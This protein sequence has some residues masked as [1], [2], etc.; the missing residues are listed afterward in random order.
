MPVELWYTNGLTHLA[1]P[2]HDAVH[3]LND[4]LGTDDAFYVI[5]AGLPA[6]DL[7]VWKAE[8][9][10][11]V[12]TDTAPPPKQ[13]IVQVAA[14]C[15]HA[16]LD[17]PHAAIT[18]VRLEANAPET[19]EGSIPPERLPHMCYTARHPAWRITYRTVRTLL[20]HRWHGRIV[21]LPRPRTPTSPLWSP[22]T[23]APGTT[24]AWV[25][26]R[27]PLLVEHH[28]PLDA[29][30][31]A[32]FC[33]PCCYRHDGQPC[34]VPNLR[35]EVTMALQSPSAALLH[36]ETSE[37]S[38][39]LRLEG[40]WRPLAAALHHAARQSERPL[41]VLAYHLRR[42]DETTLVADDASLVIVEPDWL[43][44]VRALVEADFCPRS[45]LLQRFTPRAPNA[46]AVRGNII[47]A[48]FEE[49]VAHVPTSPNEWK[50][51]IE[52]AWRMSAVHLALLNLNV[53]EFFANEV[54]P[55]LERLYRWHQA[56]P[57]PTP[58][59][60]SETFLLAPQVGLKGRI[61]A[62]WEIPGNVWVGELKTGKPWGERI[63]L[64]DQVQLAAYVLMTLARGWARPEGYQ[65]FVLYPNGDGD[66]AVR[67]DA[68]LNPHVF[69]QVVIARNRVVLI[70]H[71]GYAPFEQYSANKC[72]KCVAA[73]VCEA[74]AVL[75]GHKDT[76]PWKDVRG[77]YGFA[78]HF[79]ATTRRW[80]RTWVRLLDHEL[81][82]VKAAHAALWAMT[83]EA[84]VQT[85]ATVILDRQTDYTDA[86]A[87]GEG[88]FY[89]FAADNQSELRAGDYVLLSEAPGPLRGRMAE[90]T[91]VAIDETSLTVQ[92]DEPLEFT[93]QLVD[94]YTS[95]DLLTRQYTPLWLWLKQPPERRDL[96][97]RHRAPLFDAATPRLHHPPTIGDR[98]LNKRQQE[99]VA[100]L[101][102][103]RDYM[104][105]QGPPGTG[106]TTLIAALVRECLARGERV[107]LA[108]GT[109]T[110][111]DN[112][113][114]ALMN[115]GLGDQVV[116]LGNT[117]RTDTHVHDR[118][119]NRLAYHDDVQM[120]IEQTRRLLLEAPVLAATA[121][122][123]MRGTW[124]GTLR[125]DVAIVDEAGQM[126][127]PATLAPLRFAKRFV[128]I[129]D[130]KQL[131]PVVQSEGR[132]RMSDLM[133]EDEPPR[134]SRSLFEELIV[135]DLRR[136]GNATILLEE[137]YRMNAEICRIAS[138]R[139]YDNRLVPGTEA[140]AQARLVLD[141]LPNDA[142]APIRDPARPV[143]WV[144]TP[145]A[146]SGVPRQND[147]EA[148][149]VADLLEG[150]FAAGL[151]WPQVGVIAPFR[152]Q[153]AA[154]RRVLARR[155][156]ET[157]IA[158]IRNSVDT[159]DRFQGQERDLIIVSL[160]LYAPFVPDL[161]RDERRLNVAITRARRKLI[162]LGTLSVL[163]TEPIY[164]ALA[165]TL[166]IIP[167]R[168]GRR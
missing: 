21:P 93:P 147:I 94:Q 57:R 26:A 97:I 141:A 36:L 23:Y 89:T 66:K 108:A 54:R 129:G 80:F 117:L 114:R 13:R 77:R 148:E 6:A 64:G 161:L 50:R 69:Q 155:F 42:E 106:K 39:L 18:P 49:M 12:Y 132:R 83:P 33:L 20:V 149:L 91:I 157:A 160:S 37:G 11:L 159:V 122:T 35:G 104:L 168:R 29:A 131:P 58:T 3:A 120:Q 164:A 34:D 146:E 165:S 52:D 163:N 137:Q 31:D 19:A 9:V 62:L 86:R 118:L 72:R 158:Q 2:L 135:A 1:P 14:L 113:V 90:A 130:H 156:G 63:R 60:R 150:Y 81:T 151:R 22:T 30:D 4:V 167:Y 88:V 41:Q 99:A 101:A 53:H 103:M 143:V 107:L 112:M 48:L 100:T 153:V 46:P 128:L 124:D 82:V 136:G 7:L 25:Q 145:L 119:L 10:L 105:V 16:G 111:V 134:L 87:R 27:L 44:N 140:V 110:A 59:G 121:S 125:F 15:A 95:E 65:A 109:N 67:Y 5:V 154:I 56:E 162:L 96:V 142:L 115:V 32:A 116:R 24:A 38:R 76:R 70:D 43:V 126:T 47:H 102:R 68:A 123:W 144:D 85:G 127:L 71:M 55:I 138:R 78:R 40:A 74:A 79:D 139:W 75:L 84:R 45:Y 73:E 166:D 51:A 17:I 61:D 8:G 133:L 152:A 98:P 92:V 28:P